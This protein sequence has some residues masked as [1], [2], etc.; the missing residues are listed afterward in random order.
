MSEFGDIDTLD[1]YDSEPTI[2]PEQVTRRL[3]ELRA[4]INERAGVDTA[5]FDQL[6]DREQ[7]L[8]H[9]IGETITDWFVAHPA[10]SAEQMA[11]ELHNV[12]RYFA[13]LVG[14]RLEPW[15]DLDAD[16][17]DVAV[18]VAQAVVDWLHAEGP[19]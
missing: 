19:R 1:V 17:R 10:D 4:Y 12:R 9:A 18:A 13:S 16:H 7:A 6:T 3:H 8:A 5:Q 2:A 15:D 14:Q 11:I